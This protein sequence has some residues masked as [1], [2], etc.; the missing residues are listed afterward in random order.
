MKFCPR[1]K[2]QKNLQEF[3]KSSRNTYQ[4]ACKMCRK[5]EAANWYKNNKE[6]S[7][8]RSRKW[9]ENNRELAR[10][11]VSSRRRRLRKA[12]PKWLSVFDKRY[13]RSIYMQAR[14]LNMEV[15]HIIPLKGKN[16]SGLHVPW[17]LQII[18]KKDNCMKG[19]S[20]LCR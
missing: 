4:S 1:C 10:A 9:L 20:V 8:K 12:T 3:H 5:K 16:V 2:I 13:I 15:D 18:S 6:V 17:N 11:I 14:F 7:A 19:N